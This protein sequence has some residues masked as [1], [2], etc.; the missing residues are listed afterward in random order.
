MRPVRWL[1][2]TALVMGCG[3]MSHVPDMASDLAGPA[4]MTKLAAAPAGFGAPCQG[5]PECRGYAVDRPPG[6]LG[7]GSYLGFDYCTAMCGASAS[8]AGCW[9]GSI[10]KCVDRI[11]AGGFPE[12]DCFCAK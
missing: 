2:L 3:G 8:G 6:F 12:T 1:A 9:E 4:D 11:N 7:C 10:C 5:S